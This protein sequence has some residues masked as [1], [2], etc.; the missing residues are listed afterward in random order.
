MTPEEH[1]PLLVH[2]LEREVMRL[3]CLNPKKVRHRS[4]AT[5]RLPW[6]QPTIR[7]PVASSKMCQHRCGWAPDRQND[8]SLIV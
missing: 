2:F 5:A 8:F 3:P 7:L 4:I 6:Q 1:I